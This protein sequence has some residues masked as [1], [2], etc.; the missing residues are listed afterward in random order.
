MKKL[1]AIDTE[2]NGLHV[3][4]GHR[5]F[6]FAAYDGETYTLSRDKG[7]IRY[8]CE[9]SKYT[10]IFHNAPFDIGMLNSVGI[11]VKGEI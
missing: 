9:E 2:T 10:K 8:F 7:A 3:H 5:P 1:I 11:Q 6:L 4:Q